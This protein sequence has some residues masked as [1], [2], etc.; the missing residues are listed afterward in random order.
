MRV[1]VVLGQL[2]NGS[3]E[4]VAMPD[5]DIEAQKALVKSLILSG[6][7]LG[8]G[9]S[10]KMFSQVLRFDSYTKRCRFEDVPLPPV[11]A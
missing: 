3:W 10:A 5:K 1:S 4:P 11:E 8:T 6:G 9:R 2:K 7:K